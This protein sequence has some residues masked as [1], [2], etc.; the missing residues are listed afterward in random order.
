MSSESS[1][2]LRV[3]TGPL[4]SGPARVQSINSLLALSFV[5]ETMA[6]TF[7]GLEVFHVIS[8]ATLATRHVTR[9]HFKMGI[10]CIINTSGNEYFSSL[11]QLVGLPCRPKYVVVQAH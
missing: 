3:Y 10:Y 7:G 5:A 6:K 9:Q 8:A 11:L 1:S 2:S 4:G